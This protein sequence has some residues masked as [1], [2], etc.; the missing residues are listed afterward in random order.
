MAKRVCAGVKHYDEHTEALYRPI[1]AYAEDVLEFPIV[2]ALADWEDDLTNNR[3]NANQSLLAGAIAAGIIVYHDG[4]FTGHFNA[5]TSRGL[6][7][8]GAKFSKW[9][10]SFKLDASAL[11]IEIKQAVAVATVKSR[12]LHAGLA[13]LLLLIGSNVEHAET[14]INTT[15]AA[16]VIDRNVVEQLK[17]TVP[18]PVV[19][20]D[21]KLSIADLADLKAQVDDAIKKTV[22]ESAR[23]IA[24]AIA[25][26]ELEGA[27]ITKLRELINVALE[28]VRTRTK[29]IAER[30]T[31]LFIAKE[32]ERLYK[33][34]GAESYIWQTRL[35]ERVRPGHRVLEGHQFSWDSPPVTNHATGDRNNP[36]EDWNCRCCPLPLIPTPNE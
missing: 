7:E 25:K 20:P 36:G 2:D 32:R 34:I 24:A 8:L 27:S 26:N 29:A 12:E 23:D 11:P 33:S 4:L 22:A 10:K 35:D 1:L 3:R 13:A 6:R 17:K 5:G 9:T 18:T 19:V 28:R 15:A 14:D 16:M 21:V 30:E 31:A